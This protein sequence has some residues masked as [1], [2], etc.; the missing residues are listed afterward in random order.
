[1]I[2]ASYQL[3]H[4]D[5]CE[6]INIFPMNL[7]KHKFFTKAVLILHLHAKEVKS[8]YFF[9]KHVDKPGNLVILFS[10]PQKKVSLSLLFY[11]VH[12]GYP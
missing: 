12:V 6:N 1:M 7:L 2:V 10:F 4:T 5:T 8:K 11:L 3:P 9:H